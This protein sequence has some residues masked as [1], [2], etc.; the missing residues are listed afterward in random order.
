MTEA[1]IEGRKYDVVTDENGAT[2]IRVLVREGENLNWYWL[3]ERDI[4]D[5]WFN[6]VPDDP[7]EPLTVGG[8]AV[9]LEPEAHAALLTLR[10]A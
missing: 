8:R 2:T 1:P 4:N 3:E 9:L 6:S 10:K 5:A 7:E